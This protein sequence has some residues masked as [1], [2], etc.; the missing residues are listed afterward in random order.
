VYPKLP[1]TEARRTS[2]VI[3]VLVMEAVSQSSIVVREVRITG[4]LGVPA[5][6]LQEYT[7]FLR[8]HPLQKSTV[9]KQSEYAVASGLRHRGFLKAK[10]VPRIENVLR[11]HGSR[12]DAVLHLIVHAGLQYRIKEINFSGLA[13]EFTAG[14]LRNAIPLK[15]GDT[16][17]GEQI[18]IGIG[19]L[20]A[21]F[22]K[23]KK[24]YSAVTNMAFDDDAGTVSLTFEVMK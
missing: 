18:G 24:N 6:E 2:L 8:G 9:L 14:E 22:M 21:L 1:L 15:P 4:D 17:D 20:L 13:S 10:V 23:E 11:T 16:A 19:N 3:I 12:S 5:T 7:E